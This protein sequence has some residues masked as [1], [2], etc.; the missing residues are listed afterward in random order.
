LAGT[1]LCE[2]GALSD[3]DCT[4]VRFGEG[5]QSL[6]LLIMRNGDQVRAYVNR[7]PHFSLPLNSQPDRFLV[8]RDRHIMCA[9]HC[10]LFRFED[11]LCVDG[12]AKDRSL[13]AVPVTVI[14]GAVHIAGE[15]PL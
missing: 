1:R 3:G 5:V 9:Y 10:A 6:R 14:D 7:C 12:P 2:F 8:T 15:A 4:E 13:E 11:G